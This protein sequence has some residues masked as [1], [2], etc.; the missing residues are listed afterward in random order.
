MVCRG[1]VTVFR[2]FLGIN[3]VP[4]YSVSV[5]SVFRYKWCAEV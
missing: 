1:I 3:G 2:V 5:S 4:R